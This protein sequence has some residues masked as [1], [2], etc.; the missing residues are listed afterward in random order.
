MN[1]IWLSNLRMNE[2]FCS[3]SGEFLLAGY[4]P[5]PKQQRDYGANLHC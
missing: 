3:A 4:F 2:F 1:D 5:A